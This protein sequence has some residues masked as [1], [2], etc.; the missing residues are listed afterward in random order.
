MVNQTPRG[1]RGG[2]HARHSSAS[3]RHANPV[4]SDYDSDAPAHALLDQNAAA[5]APNPALLNRTNTDLNLAALRRHIPAIH[6][7]LSIAA[8]AVV[9]TFAPATS[10]WERAGI[11]GTYFL[12]FLAPDAGSAQ[13]PSIAAAAAAAPPRACIFVLN[14]RGLNN[15]SIDLASVG[16]FEV[17]DGIYIFRLDEGTDVLAGVKPEGDAADAAIDTTVIGIWI[18]TEDDETRMSNAV[19]VQ[20]TLRLV[21]T[22]E[23]HVEDDAVQAQGQ[24]QGQGQEQEYV[25]PA[26]AAQPTGRKLSVSALFGVAPNGLSG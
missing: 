4:T 2:G 5:P 16:H 6:S 20:E 25:P 3:H 1:K 12:C 14:R 15:V 22:G 19:M 10:S 18:H 9:Y 26:A 7:I 23:A 13:D 11:E 8:N 24:G 17:M 21:Q